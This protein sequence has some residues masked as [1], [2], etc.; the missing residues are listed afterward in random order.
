MANESAKQCE[1]LHR[2]AEGAANRNWCQGLRLI[3]L[4]EKTENGK[5]AECVRKII[6]EA[7]GVEHSRNECTEPRYQCWRKAAATQAD[8]HEAEKKEEI[9]WGGCRLSFFPN[10]TKETAEKRGKF[11]DARSR[12]HDLDVRFTRPGNDVLIHWI[13][14]PNTPVHSYY[15]N[16]DQLDHQDRRFRNRTSLFK[17]QISR[18]NASLRLTRVEIQDQGRY[19]CYTSSITSNKESFVYVSVEAPIREV[20]LQQEGNRITCS[21][22]GIYPKPQLT[23]STNPAS[24][25]MPYE[26]TVQQTEQQ[27][28]KI[29]SSL[30]FSENFDYSCT[31]SSGTNRK[32]TKMFK[33][34]SI[35]VSETETTIPCT[36]SNTPLTGLIWMF[37][38]SQ[39]ILTQNGANVPYTVSNEWKQHV[40]SVSASG[41]LTLQDLTSKQVG[42][43]TCEFS[44]AGNK[45]LTSSFLILKES[46]G[47]DSVAGIV[48]G[49][50]VL[51]I[52]VTVLVVL[53]FKFKTA[54]RQKFK[55]R[56][57]GCEKDSEQ[58]D[59]KRPLRGKDEAV[60]KKTCHSTA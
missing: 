27:L 40:K 26:P 47:A 46:Q 43:Y 25:L 36:A 19:K 3:G 18:G 30:I 56:R 58:P 39:I 55:K 16:R 51:I 1:E 24:T 37:N 14:M 33:R 44:N 21:S 15:R 22:E 29:S 11:K 50:I 6:S 53:F 20:N 59:V 57:T 52:V 8:Y 17:D 7:L 35:N 41:S 60:E 23:W 32:T 48:I 9:I 2:A 38:H 42:I 49:V 28:Y 5:T 13:Q 45:Y 31:I 10:M 12:L 34:T 54:I 4:S